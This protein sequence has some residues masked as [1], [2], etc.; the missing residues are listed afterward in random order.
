MQSLLWHAWSSSPIMPLSWLPEVN[1]TTRM[2][3]PSRYYS[4]RH[5]GPASSHPTL[6]F[7][8]GMTLRSMMETSPMLVLWFLFVLVTCSLDITSILCRYKYCKDLISLVFLWVCQL[9][10]Y[11]RNLCIHEKPF[12]VI[13]IL[14]LREGDCKVVDNL[15]AKYI[16][17]MFCFFWIHHLTKCLV[18]LRLQ[19]IFNFSC[20]RTLGVHYYSLHKKPLLNNCK[21]IK[22]ELLLMKENFT[23]TYFL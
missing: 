9:K 11:Y 6:G 19:V 15:L 3:L 18:C 14:T 1:T 10:I 21:I 7:Y 23:F 5:K 22:V 4:S 8:G 2:R 17:Q 12:I 20:V 13:I 16:I